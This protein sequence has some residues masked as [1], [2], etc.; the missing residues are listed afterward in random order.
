MSNY[1]WS[2]F[3]TIFCIQKMLRR[4]AILMLKNK[5]SFP[6]F[7]RRPC[8]IGIPK[9]AFL[10]D[11]GIRVSTP[12]SHLCHAG[13]KVNCVS[14]A[15]WAPVSLGSVQPVPHRVEGCL[16]SGS[17]VC[18]SHTAGPFPQFPSHR[19]RLLNH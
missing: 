3:R 11:W 8:S 18:S 6:D 13:R 4:I 16:W 1:P 2:E 17:L 12:V 9:L 19:D 15:S 5:N 7:S 10:W 14:L